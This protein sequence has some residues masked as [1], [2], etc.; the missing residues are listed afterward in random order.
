MSCQAN[1]SLY[2]G[3]CKSA[4]QTDLR[5]RHSSCQI[6]VDKDEGLSWTQTDIHL[7]DHSG[8]LRCATSGISPKFDAQQQKSMATFM[9]GTVCEEG[10]PPPSLL[11]EVCEQVSLVWWGGPP[12]VFQLDNS[13]LFQMLRPVP[14]SLI[15]LPTQN[16]WQDTLSLMFSLICVW[17]NGWANH[18]DAGDLR[19]HHTHYD[20]TVM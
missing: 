8:T 19:L 1:I 18:R 11:D 3:V 9:L 13:S 14:H 10:S 16:P 6:C 17:T 2:L 12:R 15:S 5:T 4:P 7:P 20:V